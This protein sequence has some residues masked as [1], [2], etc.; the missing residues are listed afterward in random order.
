MRLK[1]LF[2]IL[3]LHELRLAEGS[4][5]GGAEKK[6]DRALR[7]LERPLGVFM[8]ELIRQ[9]KCRRSLTDL[10]AN[11]RSKGAIRGRV[12][13]TTR[14]GAQSRQEKDSNRSFHLCSK[15]NL[16]SS[17]ARVNAFNTK[18]ERL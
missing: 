17:R 10:Q 15:F 11:R 9:S 7:P 8:A 12:F 1:P 4:P 13:L 18:I 2:C 6:E 14:K 5:I 3:Q 16:A